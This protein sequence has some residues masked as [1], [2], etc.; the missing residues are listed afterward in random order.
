MLTARY[1]QDPPNAIQIE[2]TEGCSMFCDFC[3][4]HGIREGI[5]DYKFMSIPVAKSI[6]SSI[7]E[8]GWTSRLEFAMHGEPSMN[9]KFLEIIK[10]FRDALPNNQIMM[11]SNGSGFIKKDQITKLFEAGA[12]ILALDDYADGFIS[13]VDVSAHKVFHYPKEDKGNPH[14]RYPKRAL[15]FV[16]IIADIGSTITGVHGNLTNHCGSA[17]PPSSTQS[18][19]AKPFR[20][21]AIRW[22]GNVAICCEDW[23]GEYN[24]GSVVNDGI[25]SVWNNDRFNSARKFLIKGD[26][27]SVFPCNKCNNRSYRVGLLPDKL[28]KQKMPDPDDSD[29]LIVKEAS[30][31]RLVKTI[32]L[33]PWEK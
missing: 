29:H 16:T 28:G 11:T 32:V 6:A 14:R 4:L 10:I 9:P 27:A 26:R 17:F 15:P 24:V 8:T 23:R 19:C 7:K 31:H 12:D 25:F 3:G 20:E 2:L 1:N 33:R 30:E 21:I 22:D 18:R 13:R 5:G